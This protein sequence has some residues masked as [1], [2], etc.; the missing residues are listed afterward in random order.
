MDYQVQTWHT[1]HSLTSIFFQDYLAIFLQSFSLLSLFCSCFC[2]R[3]DM[4]FFS[5]LLF[6]YSC[7]YL[8][9]SFSSLLLFFFSY[10]FARSFS[11]A[12]CHQQ[13]NPS[14]HFWEFIIFVPFRTP[15]V[16]LPRKYYF[17]SAYIRN[18]LLIC[19]IFPLYS[20]TPNPS[21]WNQKKKIITLFKTPHL[22]CL[23]LPHES[24]TWTT[25]IK[26]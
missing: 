2:S 8:R 16:F 5:L 14:H 7:V 10:L 3:R 21:Q 18:S 20:I 19:S 4:S 15:F 6:F 13:N 1:A 23:S 24:Q 9:K 12:P 17:H 25:H 26:C 11:G 22:P